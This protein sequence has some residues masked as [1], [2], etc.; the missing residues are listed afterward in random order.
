MRHLDTQQ[1][2]ASNRQVVRQRGKL[3][4]KGEPEGLGNLP[5]T[6]QINPWRWIPAAAAHR[7]RSILYRHCLLLFDVKGADPRLLPWDW[8]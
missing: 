7:N 2:N 8:R 5:V 6:N 4:P 3:H 1:P